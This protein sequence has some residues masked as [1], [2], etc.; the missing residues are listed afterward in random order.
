MKCRINQHQICTREPKLKPL[1]PSYGKSNV[2]QCREGAVCS[3]EASVVW[4]PSR[5]LLPF[6]QRE[7][8]PKMG[9]K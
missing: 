6:H 1:T 5:L 3:S 9:I 4:I 8:T 2:T 7:T